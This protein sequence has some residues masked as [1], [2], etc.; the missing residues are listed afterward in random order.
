[1]RPVLTTILIASLAAAAA[2]ATGSI[3]G[4]VYYEDTLRPVET[5]FVRIVTDRGLDLGTVSTDEEGR[6]RVDGIPAGFHRLQAWRG[7]EASEILAT[8]AVRPGEHVKHVRF[9]LKPRAVVRIRVETPSGREPRITRCVLES[10]PEIVEG[11]KRS[12]GSYEFRAGPGTWRLHVHAIGFRTHVETIEL[13]EFDRHFTTIELSTGVSVIGKALDPE[14]RPI[15]GA[16]VDRQRV[17]T[18]PC[19]GATWTTDARGRFDLAGAAPARTRF[20]IS[21]LGYRPRLV[22]LDLSKSAFIERRDF[23]LEPRPIG[24]DITGVVVDEKGRP[25]PGLTVVAR[26]A[27]ES[28]HAVTKTDEKGAF[29]FEKWPEVATYVTTGTAGGT[30][31][32]DSVPAR[33]GGESVRLVSSRRATVEVRA[34]FPDGTAPPLWRVRA[35]SEDD[36]IVRNG[37]NRTLLNLP[38]GESFTLRLDVPGFAPPAAKTIA[39]RWGERT[40]VTFPV[41]PRPHD[42]TVGLWVLSRDDLPLDVPTTVRLTRPDGSAILTRPD[43]MGN[44][45]LRRLAPGTYRVDVLRIG[46]EDDPRSPSSEVTVAARQGRRLVMRVDPALEVVGDDGDPEKPGPFRLGDALLWASGSRLESKAVLTELLGFYEERSRTIKVEWVREGETM[47]GRA[48]VRE[49]ARY[50]LVEALR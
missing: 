17:D 48:A 19:E 26:P 2:A 37:G 38:G 27:R 40:V 36:E 22:G 39:T 44:L 1:M 32:E 30:R 6:Y 21:A 28:A 24:G 10:P 42:A 31:R 23:V 9:V 25:V 49:V 43:A 11:E 33:A 12:T 3:S 8:I 47:T 18:P 50:R 41:D 46:R 29:R 15:E 5:T 7:A 35:A 45:M 13:V 20:R 14:G 34:R 4:R 16:V